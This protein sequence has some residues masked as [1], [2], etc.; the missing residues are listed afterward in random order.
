MRRQPGRARPRRPSLPDRPRTEG[1]RRATVADRRASATRPVPG[2]AH[3]AYGGLVTA[4]RS[5]VPLRAGAPR[6]DVRSRS[7]AAPPGRRRAQGPH[8]RRRPSGDDR[9]APGRARPRRRRGGA[10]LPRARSRRRIAGVAPRGG[11]R[12]SWGSRRGADVVGHQRPLRRHPRR[13]V[14]RRRLRAGRCRRPRRAGRPRLRR[15]RRR[16][17]PDRRA[18]DQ[19][20]PQRE[21]RASRPERCRPSC[22]RPADRRRRRVDHLHLGL[23]GRA[24]GRRRHASVGGRVRRCRGPAVPRRRP[25]PARPGRPRAGRAVRRLRRVVRGDVAGV[26]QRGL[27][28]ARAPLAG[29]LG[30]GPRPVAGR[31]PHHRG[32]DRAHAGRPVAVRCPRPGAT[33]DLRGRGLPSGVGRAGRR[34]RPRGV[35]HLRA[36]RGHRGRLRRPPRR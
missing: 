30:D 34:P 18:V 8:P 13:P 33:A 29:A 7:I 1:S 32:L 25:R 20:R 23:D 26:A 6:T 19:G 12:G 15:G 22:R 24:Q 17:G 10:D 2:V 4:A 5:C 27:P 14:G 21:R 31:E 28:R 3:V 9:R 36:D 11:G 35:E 16:R